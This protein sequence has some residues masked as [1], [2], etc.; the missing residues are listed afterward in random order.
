MHAFARHIVGGFAK[1][2]GAV[3]VAIFCL[4]MVLWEP[5]AFTGTGISCK[6]CKKA[7]KDT[8][9][10]GSKA[11]KDTQKAAGKALQDAQK[12]GGKALHD[13]QKG[14]GK[15]LQVPGKALKSVLGGRGP[16]NSESDSPCEELPPKDPNYCGPPGN[17]PQGPDGGSEGGGGSGLSSDGG[18]YPSE[19][20]EEPKK[21]GDFSLGSTEPS[22]QG[23]DKSVY[24]KLGISG[25][26]L[27]EG[28]TGR[29]NPE[30]AIP[31]GEEGEKMPEKQAQ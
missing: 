27:P 9:K 31:Q 12:A 26:G 17:S 23:D 16:G 8:Q 10:A 20:T 11:A 14:I 19:Q 4:Q 1:R 18:P 6:A 3:V 28:A 7:A 30:T 24:D 29:E 15:A 21:A 25:L 5:P 22:I 13:T 2:T